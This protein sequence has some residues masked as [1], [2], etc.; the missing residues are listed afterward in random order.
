LVSVRIILY[1][2]SKAYLNSAH[3]QLHIRGVLPQVFDTTIDHSQPEVSTVNLHCQ[4]SANFIAGLAN[5]FTSHSL[6]ASTSTSASTS[7][8]IYV[9]NY[10]MTFATKTPHDRQA[11][12]GIFWR[13][14]PLLALL[15]LIRREL[16]RFPGVTVKMDANAGA[17]PEPGI[18]GGSFGG[19]F[20]LSFF[21]FLFYF[22]CILEL[23][24]A[25]GFCLNRSVGD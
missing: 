9:K 25:G 3:P 14:W 24:S 17:R 8:I 4:L 19:F 21:L 5:F 6:T 15:A 2:A 12:Y 16:S 7:A 11:D 10:E 20:F 13:L 23:P 18:S 1:P 22:F